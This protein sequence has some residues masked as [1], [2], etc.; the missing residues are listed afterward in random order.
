MAPIIGKV[1]EAANSL[2]AYTTG[3]RHLLHKP[4]TLKFPQQRYAVENLYGHL[5]GWLKRR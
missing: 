1:R 5:R 3:L 4:Y 2:V